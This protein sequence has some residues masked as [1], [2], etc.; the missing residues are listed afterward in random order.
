[1]NKDRLDAIRDGESFV[2]DYSYYALPVD[3]WA[4]GVIMFNL[5]CG[6]SPFPYGDT[7][8]NYDN[9][10]R[11]KVRYPRT[12]VNQ[13]TAEAKDLIRFIL[14]PDPDL[15]P[16]IDD[17][18]AHAFF[19]EPS[20]GIPLRVLPRSFPKTILNFPLSEEFIKSLQ[21]RA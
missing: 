8:E 12:M 9:I 2:P 20:D 15:R 16:S 1:M 3:I 6:K 11:A 21:L 4:L 19:T 17:I 13:V 5:L 18:L 10:K 7:K 14:N